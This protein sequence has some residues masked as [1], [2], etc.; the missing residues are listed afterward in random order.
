VLLQIGNLLI[1]SVFG[2]FIFLLL[3]RFYMQALRAPFRN[4]AG[5]LVTALTN[6]M[7]RPARRFIPGLYGMDLSSLM[8]A[9]LLETLMLVL[10]RLLVGAAPGG[11]VIGK[12]ILIGAVDLARQSMYLL[13]GIVLVQVILS[14]VSTYNPLSG[15]LDSLTRPFYSFFRRFIPTI[16]NIDLSPI[17]ILLAAQIAI[18]VLNQLMNIVATAF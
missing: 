11:A 9:W 16:G 1:E 7:V 5:E 15:V 10:L 17:F 6:W 4:P 8:L 18:I 12:L 2:F 14:W 13:I 3:L